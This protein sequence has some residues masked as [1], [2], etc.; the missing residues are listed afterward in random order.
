MLSLS[1]AKLLVILVV[2][3]IV[4]GPEKLPGV[5]RQI[6]AA[7]GDIRRWRTRLENEVR[8]VFPDL[9]ATHDV[10]QVVRSP[11]AFLD[12]LADEH[13]HGRSTNGAE[14]NGS[15]AASSPS[16]PPTSLQRTPPVGGSTGLSGLGPA[17]VEP[18]DDPNMN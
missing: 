16:A 1:P 15:A 4:L 8:D 13:E 7:W 14:A 11:L 5:A 12:R 6:G 10:A 2:A 3:M 18:A 9:P 17:G